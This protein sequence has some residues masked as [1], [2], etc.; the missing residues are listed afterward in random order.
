MLNDVSLR[1]ARPAETWPSASRRVATVYWASR[2]TPSAISPASASVFGPVP[3]MSTGTGCCGTQSNRT[4][5]SRTYRPE[6]VTDRPASRSLRAVTYSRINVSGD[7]TAA[8]ACRIQSC[9]PWP[10]PTRIRPGNI[11]SRVAI[12]IAVVTTLRNGAGST[13]SPTVSVSD[14]ASATAAA[15]MPPCKKQSSHSHSSATPSRSAAA[16]VCRKVSGR[17]S[18]RNTTPMRALTRRTLVLRQHR[19]ITSVPASMPSRS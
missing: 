16:A 8:P 1:R 11:D 12:S 19:P 7:A 18:G 3:P 6:T 17:K 14:D 15:A 2:I 4:L 5:A 10:I 13:P 9:T